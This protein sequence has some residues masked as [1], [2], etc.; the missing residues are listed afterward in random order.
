V[1]L[2]WWALAQ[3][4]SPQFLPGPLRVARS[5]AGLLGQAATYGHLAA[6]G[7]RIL[8]GFAL[9]MGVGIAAGILMGARRRAEAFLDIWV[10]VGLTIPAPAWAMVCVMVFGLSEAGAVVAIVL[11]AAPFVAVNAWQGVKAMEPALV[12]M[13]RVFRFSR[14]ALLWEVVFPQL[15]PFLLAAARYGFGLVWKVVVIVEMIAMGDGVGWALT[16]AFRS[17][18]MYAVL[19]WTAIFSGVMLA[20]ELGILRRLEARVSAWRPVAPIGEPAIPA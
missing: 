12:E 1:L 11:L 14:R 5:I 16:S 15:A 3:A 9:S 13:A 20:V 17:F 10:V 18:E 8:A 7:R 6:T 2:L 4:F 19:A